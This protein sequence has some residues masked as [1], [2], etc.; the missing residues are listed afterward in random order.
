MWRAFDDED[1]AAFAVLSGDANPLHVDGEAA[2][3]LMFD[4]PLVHGLHAVIWALDC[5]LGAAEG[6]RRLRRIA[7]RF[8]R[9]DRRR[10]GGGVPDTRGRT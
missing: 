1:Q 5:W 3:R 2:R 10:R 8:P 6:R 7:A 4:R 9:P